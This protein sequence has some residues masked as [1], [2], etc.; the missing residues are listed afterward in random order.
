M[1]RLAYIGGCARDWNSVRAWVCSQELLHRSA[2]FFQ[3]RRPVAPASSAAAIKGVSSLCRWRYY[4][5]RV[6]PGRGPAVPNDSSF[7][8]RKSGLRH[9]QRHHVQTGVSPS[10]TNTPSSTRIACQQLIERIRQIAGIQTADFPHSCM[11]DQRRVPFF[12]GVMEM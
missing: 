12:A 10:M 5:V 9:E 3:R 1:R 8:E 2:S 7:V 4:N 6:A 11:L